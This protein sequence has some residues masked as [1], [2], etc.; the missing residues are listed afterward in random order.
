[1]GDVKLFRVEGEIL[2]P[3]YVT[4]FSKDLRAVKPDDAVE[5]VFTV[6]G[7]QHRVKRVHIKVTSVAEITVDETEDM[8]IRDLSRG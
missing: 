7:S 6:L 8:I 4:T 1:M 2:S 3:T 5:Q